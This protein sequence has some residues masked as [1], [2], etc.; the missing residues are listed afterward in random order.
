MIGVNKRHKASHT[1][2][3]D[4]KKVDI[5]PKEFEIITYLIKNKNIALSRE[6]LLSKIWGYDYYG[7]YRTI[8]THIKMLRNNLGKYRDLIKTVRA[9]GYKFEI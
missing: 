4:N 9:V 8:D 3:I 7:D 6:T 1:L 5:T 2:K